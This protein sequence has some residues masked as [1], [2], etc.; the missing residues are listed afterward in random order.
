M[1]NRKFGWHSGDLE[2]YNGTFDNDVSVGGDLTITGALTASGN[3]T[4]GNASTDTITV[5]GK[6]TFAEWA[7]TA[8][9][10]SGVKDVA[11]TGLTSSDVVVVQNITGTSNSGA[12][13]AITATGTLSVH[14]TDA[15]DANTFYYEVRAWSQIS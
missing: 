3:W 11:I 12:L 5:N 2:A 14:S 9:L 7:G 15:S 10:S 1:V 13:A 6:L 4:L 8:T